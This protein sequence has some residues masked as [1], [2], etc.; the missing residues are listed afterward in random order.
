[1]IFNEQDRECFVTPPPIRSA[2]G[3]LREGSGSMGTEMLRCA[4]HDST[5]CGY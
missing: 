4:Q 5:G 1:M 3:K 2:Q